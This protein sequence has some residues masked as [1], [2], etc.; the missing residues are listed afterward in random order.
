MN[1][2]VIVV[3]TNGKRRVFHLEP[4]NGGADDPIFNHRCFPSKMVRVEYVHL[5]TL[6]DYFDIP[7]LR[8][9]IFDCVHENY[10][11]AG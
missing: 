3:Q 10:S 5:F 1:D 2:C 6:A 11:R 7:G 4:V 8:E 9:K